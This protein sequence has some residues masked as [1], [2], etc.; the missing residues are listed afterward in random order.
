MTFAEMVRL[1]PKLKTLFDDAKNHKRTIENCNCA[2]ACDIAWYKQYKPRLIELVGWK[3]PIK[4]LSTR[5]VY[6]LAYQTVYK[7]MPGCD[8][9]PNK[10]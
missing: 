7:A 1:E 6:D 2:F 5:Q 9:C 4:E 8:K 10:S 3:S